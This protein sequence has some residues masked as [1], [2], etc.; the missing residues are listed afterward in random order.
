MNAEQKTVQD[1][2]SDKVAYTTEPNAE[3]PITGSL[4]D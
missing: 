3:P 2:S 1:A 4:K